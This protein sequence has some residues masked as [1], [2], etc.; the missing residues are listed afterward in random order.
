MDLAGLF[1][2]GGPQQPKASSVAAT[3]FGGYQNQQD[4]KTILPWLV[5]GAVVAIVVIAA[6]LLSVIRK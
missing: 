6:V 5:G 4:L 1:G 2:S 3:I